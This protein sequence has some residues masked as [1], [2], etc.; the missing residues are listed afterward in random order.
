MPPPAGG[1]V[2]R[3]WYDEVGW[4]LLALLVLVLA[5]LAAW[6]FV[7]HRGE[8][9]RTVP[10]VTGLPVAA[11]VNTLQARGFK[12]R[13]VTVVHPERAGTVF[14]ELPTG[15]SRAAKG[16]T[17]QLLSSKGPATVPVPN[18]VGLTDASGRARLVAAGFKVTEA[19]VF[20]RQPPGSVIAQTPAAGSKVGKN[21]TVHLKV[22]KGTGLVIVPDV[23]GDTVG[24]AE[25]LLAKAGLKGVVQLRVPSAQTA[26]TVVAQNPPGGQ[27]RR[28]SA[29]NLNVSTGTGGAAGTTGSSGAGGASGPTGPTGTP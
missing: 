3:R 24:N 29:V 7:F 13:I 1:P 25:T 17:V 19:R 8:S 12:V 10:A 20:S 2:G 26:G 21:T 27:A 14:R 28:G 11:A 16:S 4:A 18:A 5:G 9:R 15:G 23:V 22:S 6:W